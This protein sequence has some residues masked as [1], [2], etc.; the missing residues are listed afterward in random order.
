MLKELLLPLVSRFSAFNVFQYI[1]FRS[2][3]AAVTALF[4]SFLFGPWL[5]RKLKNRKA[6]QVIREDGPATHLA[7]SGT[8]TM[9]GL[10][11]LLS[12]SVS[13]LL[14]QDISNSFTWIALIS[15]LGFG[16]IGFVDDYL[17]IFRKSSE[18]L[19]A[20]FKFSAQVLLSLLIMVV[21]YINGNAHTTLL[22]LPFLKNPV[23]DMGLFYIPFGMLILV[24]TSN[25]VNLTDGLDGLASGLILLVG[26][27]FAAISYISGRADFAAYLQIPYL[28]ES[29]ELTVLCFALAGASIGFLWYNA[30]PAEIFMGDT[31]SLSLGGVIGVIALM[32]KKEILLVIIGGVFVLEALSVIIQVVFFK[33]RGKRVF[34][35]APLH[36][37][38][39]KKGWDETKVVVRFW[40]LGGLFTILSLST[41]KIQ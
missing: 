13:V 8:P 5:I 9:G 37:H 10:M 25:A 12:L 20:R 7:K 28:P 11:I 1:T 6:E 23:L 33:L 17:K 31:G 35:M 27:P 24:G 2:A 38:F 19:Q 30:H 21:L 22:Y 26:L 32:T 3:Y 34:R 41:L 40:I 14:W 29:A 36:H 4:I 18:G 16:L 15:L 39:E